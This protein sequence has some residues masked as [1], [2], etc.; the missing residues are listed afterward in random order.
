MYLK[1][2]NEHDKICIKYFDPPVPFTDNGL[3]VCVILYVIHALTLKSIPLRHNERQMLSI[4]KRHH[5]SEHKSMSDE[6]EVTWPRLRLLHD[7]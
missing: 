4:K 5:Y 1:W 6:N 2:Y 7:A 3:N